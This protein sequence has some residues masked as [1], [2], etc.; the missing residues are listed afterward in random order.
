ML[1]LLLTLSLLMKQS[2]RTCSVLQRSAGLLAWLAIPLNGY[3]PFFCPIFSKVNGYAP[4]FNRVLWIFLAFLTLFIPFFWVGM[5][6]FI[7]L[8]DGISGISFQSNPSPDF[9]SNMWLTCILLN[10]VEAGFTREELRLAMEEEN[11]ETRPLWKPMH[12][13]PVFASAPF[14]GDESSVSENRFDRGLCLPSHPNLTDEDL[15]RV[16]DVIKGLAEM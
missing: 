8:L 7:Q 10:P 15:Q 5:L 11:I 13:Q 2:E 3:S 14:Y 6:R 12:L 9:H 1:R 16:V 4:F